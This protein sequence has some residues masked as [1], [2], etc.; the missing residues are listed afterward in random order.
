MSALCKT[1][2]WRPILRKS[3]SLKSGKQLLFD[4]NWS[5]DQRRTS[6]LGR[7]QHGISVD[8]RMESDYCACVTEKA[9]AVLSALAP[10][11]SHTSFQKILLLS[12][13]CGSFVSSNLIKENVYANEPEARSYPACVFQPHQCD[14]LAFSRFANHSSE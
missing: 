12:P 9:L 2:G 4:D 8:D 10:L 1:R 3:L 5:T 13:N 6:Q 11:T 14:A 7:L